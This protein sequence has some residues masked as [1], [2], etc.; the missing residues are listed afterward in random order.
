MT[1][2]ETAKSTV[3]DAM[4]QGRET[5]DKAGRAV[6]GAYKAARQYA[7]DESLSLDL[8]DLVRREPWLA[9]AAA[10]AIG[11]VAARIIRRVS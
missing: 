11:Y 3:R 7:E 8:G 4:D 1:P 5:A 6:K 9:V 2:E 10:F